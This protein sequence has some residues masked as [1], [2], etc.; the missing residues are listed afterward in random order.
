MEDKILVLKCKQG[1]RSALAQIYEKYKANLLLLAMALLNDRAA[2]EDVVHDVFVAFVDSLKGFRL[3]G[4]LK[5]YLMTCT[6][7]KARD[8]LRTRSVQ[9]KISGSTRPE[10]YSQDPLNHMVCNEQVGLLT[11]GLEQL[12]YEQ[13]EIVMLHIQAGLSL[14]A[15]ARELGISANTAKSRYRYGVRKLRLILN[16]EVTT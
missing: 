14:R 6:A 12:P 10:Q 8:A 2:A 11:D 3:T 15:I 7:N 16:G 5:A 1:S 4:S 13:R 9:S